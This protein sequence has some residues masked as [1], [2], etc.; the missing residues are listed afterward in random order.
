MILATGGTLALAGLL[1]FAARAAIQ[2]GFRA[3]H[4]TMLAAPGLS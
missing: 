2:R 4:L 3:P 1:H